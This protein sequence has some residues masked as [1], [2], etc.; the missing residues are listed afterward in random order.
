MRQ[1]KSRDW[2]YSAYTLG[3]LLSSMNAIIRSNAVSIL[4]ELQR[5]TRREN[6]ESCFNELKLYGVCPKCGRKM[7]IGT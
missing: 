3:E 5:G 2:D 6:C 4:K 7:E 1:K